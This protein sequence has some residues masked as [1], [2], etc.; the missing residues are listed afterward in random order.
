M[1]AENNNEENKPTEIVI[2][3]AADIVVYEEYGKYALPKFTVG[4]NGLEHA[5]EFL[6]VQ[7]VRGNVPTD[8]GTL[9]KASGITVEG[10]LGMALF[11]LHIKFKAVPSKETAKAIEKLEEAQLWLMKRNLDRSSRKVQYTYEK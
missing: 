11:D 6:E 9:E 1:K 3:G 7:Y 5:G 2:T 4:D 10:L 8:N